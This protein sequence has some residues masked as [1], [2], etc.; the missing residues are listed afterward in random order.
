MNAHALPKAELPFNRAVLK[1]ARERRRLTEGDAAR[2]VGTSPEAVRAWEAGD[3]VPTVRQARMLAALYERSFIEFF[4]DDIPRLTES[5]LVPDYRLHRGAPEPGSDDRD[6]LDIQEWAEE[7]RLNAIDLFAVMGEPPPRLSVELT[8]SLEENVETAAAR[9]RAALGFKLS[10]QIGKPGKKRDAL[11]GLLRS[12]LES[13]GILV[14]KESALAKFQARGMCIVADPLPVIVFSA[15]AYSAQLFTMAHELGHV[16]LRESAISGPPP[17]KG[18]PSHGRRVEEWCN[19]FAAAFL[20]PASDLTNHLIIPKA[21]HPTI[22]DPR[23]AQL[24]QRYAVSPHAML[25]RLVEVGY[26]QGRYY[27]EVKRDEFLEQERAFKARGR[28]EYYGSR[29]RSAR[30]DFYTALVLEAWNTGRITN[31]NAG[32][33]MGIKNLRHLEDIRKNFWN[34]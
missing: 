10:D 16:C 6:L 33:F 30:G 20:I 27:W 8:A 7:V 14:L 2:R 32:E 34:R 9:V 22:S 11:A 3:A 26:V 19:A 18:R 1:W 21:P 24:A 5:K 31:H 25:L 15:E 29:Y 23:L 17:S 12:K 28:S 13:A 4:L